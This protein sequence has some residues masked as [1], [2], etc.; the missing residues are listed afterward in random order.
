[1]VVGRTPTPLQQALLRR[2]QVAAQQL[3][4][5]QQR[6][7]LAAQQRAAALAAR[8]AVGTRPTTAQAAFGGDKPPLPSTSWT[9][10]QQNTALGRLPK[11]NATQAPALLARAGFVQS[12]GRYVH[13][14]G[15]WASIAG[16][17]LA[18]GWKGYTLGELPYN[19]RFSAR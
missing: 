11:T 8:Q 17:R 1:M 6:A 7:A 4:A 3:A 15:S 5:A 16:G 13:P 18:L 19:N 12:G 10:W 14:D 9:W 2:Q